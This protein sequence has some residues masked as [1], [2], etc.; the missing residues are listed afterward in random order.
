MRTICM[1]VSLCTVARRIFRVTATATAAAVVEE[2][3]STFFPHGKCILFVCV[4]VWYV[5]KSVQLYGTQGTD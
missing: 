2:A 1:A 5:F 3:K 4:C